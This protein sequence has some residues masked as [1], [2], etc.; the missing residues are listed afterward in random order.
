MTIDWNLLS[1]LNGLA[2]RSAA[3]DLIVRL[4]VNDYAITTALVVVTFGLWFFGVTAEERERNQR[5]VLM[6][7]ASLIVANLFVKGLNLV[8]Y[9]PRPFA[10]HDLQLLFYHPSDSSFPSNPA[11]VGFCIAT[12]VWFF[13]RTAGWALYVLAGLLGLARLIGGVHYPSD[14]LGGALIGTL[15]AYL[16][17]RKLGFAD[18]LWTI[19][20]RR[21]RSLLLA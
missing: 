20:I 21:M 7:G 14:V 13:N 2:G 12:A 11:S 10:G 4:L 15:S 5:G 3:F 16:V 17:V 19:V 9:R 6:A 18:R 1:L 8:Y